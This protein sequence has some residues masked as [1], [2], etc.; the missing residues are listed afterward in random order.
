MDTSFGLLPEPPT[1]KV[2][3]NDRDAFKLFDS[4]NESAELLDA[5]SE[6]RLAPHDYKIFDDA[7]DNASWLTE[8]A[9]SKAT[10]TKGK[11]AQYAAARNETGFFGDETL[12]DSIKRYFV[13]PD[14]RIAYKSPDQKIRYEYSADSF[15]TWLKQF[16]AELATELPTIGAEAVIEATAGK[17]APVKKFALFVASH[18]GQVAEHRMSSD[19]PLLSLDTA[20]QVG[21]QM[22]EGILGLGVPEGVRKLRSGE[23]GDTSLLPLT[24]DAKGLIEDNQKFFYEQTGVDLPLDAASDRTTRS[25]TNVGLFLRQQPESADLFDESDALLK[26]AMEGKLDEVLDV[27]PNQGMDPFLIGEGLKEA[28]NRARSRL[29]ENRQKAVAAHYRRAHENL[30]D[31]VDVAQLV[32]DLENQAARLADEFSGPMKSIIRQLTIK[33]DG[34]IDYVTDSKKIHSLRE[35]LDD[36]IERGDG[37]I[38][39]LVQARQAVDR[40]LKNVDGFVDADST[41]MEMTNMMM[42]ELGDFINALSKKP[43]N[44]N[45]IN[46]VNQFF[47]GNVTPKM[48]MD[49]KQA[50]MRNPEF[51]GLWDELVALKFGLALDKA[52]KNDTAATG[53]MNIWRNL[54]NELSERTTTGKA[55]RAAIGDEPERLAKFNNFVRLSRLAGNASGVTSQTQILTGMKDLLKSQGEFG[56]TDLSGI[57]SIINLSRRYGVK[58]TDEAYRRLLRRISHQFL[59]RNGIQSWD[60][61]TENATRAIEGT[62]TF[63]MSTPSVQAISSGID[64]SGNRSGEERT[65]AVD[66][67][68]ALQ[69]QSYGLTQ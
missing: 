63:P 37:N 9:A 69:G 7:S 54:A 4:G 36:K 25:M 29:M 12:D 30:A 39:D 3:S 11:I 2:S 58:V 68:E 33:G 42:K 21:R 65:M 31:P 13:A 49:A 45:Y 1:E 6:G 67:F 5:P 34:G 14:G 40:V 10:T 66:E 57:G 52:F 44:T 50:F 38:A 23:L 16:S 62:F 27:M 32:F 60:R 35:M 20:S 59:S 18:F 28:G 46:I 17:F 41:F 19:E 43:D 8:Y 22:S 64:A 48:V 47:S 61:L 55:L 53:G 51:S 24:D 26:E 15:A 56:V